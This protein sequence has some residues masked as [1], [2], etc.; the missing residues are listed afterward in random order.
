MILATFS[1]YGRNAFATID[2]ITPGM[3]RILP[4]SSV[5]SFF[6]TLA[7][8]YCIISSAEKTTTNFEPYPNQIN[9]LQI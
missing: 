8:T 6:G 2:C 3:E 4:L 7:T 9:L 5:I 1:L